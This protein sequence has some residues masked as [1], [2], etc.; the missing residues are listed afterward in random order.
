LYR[1]L[2]SNEKMEV[3]YAHFLQ[4]FH[5]NYFILTVVV[6]LMLLNWGIESV[7]WKLLIDKIHPISWLDSIE[8]ILFGV[9][10]SLFTPS[11]IGEFGGRVFALNTDRKQAIVST[12]LGSIAQIVV[13]LSLG[14]FGLLLYALYFKKADAYLLTAFIFVFLLMTAAIHFCYYNLD[15]VTNKFSNFSYLA[16]IKKYLHIIDLYNTRVFIQLEILSAVRYGIYCLQFVLLLKF[17]GFMLPLHL[18]M[19]LVASMFFVQTINPINIALID[20]G[21]RGNVAAYFLLPFTDNSIAI[22]A[23]TISLWFINL[24]VPAII[25]GISALRFRFFNED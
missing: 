24:I 19:I 5:G 16:R 10:F 25:G 23:T 18:A 17:F 13:N 7:K 6:I 14:S 9:T 22:L 15:V 1:Q 11:R 2:F 12:L 20:F 3:A 4:T 8:G 21:F